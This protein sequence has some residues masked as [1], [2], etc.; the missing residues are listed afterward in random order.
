VSDLRQG[1]RHRAKLWVARTDNDEQLSP[2][3]AALEGTVASLA[4]DVPRAEDAAERLAALEHAVAD[5]GRQLQVRAVMDWIEHATLR[6]APLVSVVLP[7]RD[8]RDLLPRAIES[9][10]EQSYGN[11]ELLIVDDGSVDGTAELL[12]GVAGDRVRRFR[13]HGA[14]ACAARNV[15]LAQAR[16]EL[17]AYL[18]DDNMMHPAWLKAVVWGF[19]QRPEANVLYGGYVVDDAWRIKKKRSGDLPR[20]FFLP[21]DHHQVAHRSIAD[22]GCIAHRA[23]LPE[24]RFDESLREM[25]DWD[26]FLRLTRA[27]PPLALPA[28]AC[29][30]TTDAPNRLSHGPTFAAD[31][32]A[33]RAK[34]RR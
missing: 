23:G 8:R 14:G 33:V 13:H 25:G 11:W 30:Y 20:L 19:E 18:D 32:A 15:A 2:R 22:M 17:I 6:S 16:G 3:V 24:A 34:N 26:L 27:A 9:V 10:Q 12:A 21:Y 29:F 28:I 1:W 4:A 5:H 31:V 7:T